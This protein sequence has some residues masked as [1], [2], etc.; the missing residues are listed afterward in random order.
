MSAGAL[1]LLARLSSGHPPPAWL[2]PPH[3]PGR[4]RRLGQLL[5]QGSQWLLWRVTGGEA[6]V[7]TGDGLPA[8]KGRLQVIASPRA[9]DFRAGACVLRRGTLEG[10]CLRLGID[11]SSPVGLHAADSDVVVVSGRRAGQDV[12]VHCCED[13]QRLA[14][15]AGSLHLAHRWLEP[16]GWAH[17]LPRVLQAPQVGADDVWVMVQQ[18]LAGHVLSASGLDADLLQAHLRAAVAPLGAAGPGP[19]APIGQHPRVSRML[20]R[21]G[22]IS[23]WSA[24]IGPARQAL[25]R[26]PGAR[27]STAEHGDYW[28]DNLLFDDRA[29][30]TGIVDWERADAPGV[31]GCDAVHLVI[32]SFAAWRGCPQW[33]VP[34]MLWDGHCEPV[35]ERLFDVVASA[36]GLGRDDL[37][38]VALLVWLRHLDLQA[39]TRD[40]WSAERRHEWLDEPARS[41]RRWLAAASRPVC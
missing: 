38:F 12:V 10:L 28:L 14:R 29:K 40:E 16:L 21:L 31:W 20:Q 6:L 33:Q 25:L 15:Y 1:R 11:A 39:D 7:L 35:L 27:L 36:L 13:P 19:I 23:E 34:C 4:A 22:D 26:W 37:R 9:S 3:W 24:A 8:A 41:A 5:Y 2:Y 30:L 18:R 17:V 32:H